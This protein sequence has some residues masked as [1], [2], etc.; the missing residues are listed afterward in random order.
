MNSATAKPNAPNSPD[1][2]SAVRWS[3][4]LDSLAGR[5]ERRANKMNSAPAMNA[6]DSATRR[7]MVVIYCELAEMIRA[8][9]EKQSNEKLT[10]A[11]PKTPGLA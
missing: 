10:D 8:E 1:T 6:E 4:L 5:L 9:V 2:V 3:D 11:G 7:S